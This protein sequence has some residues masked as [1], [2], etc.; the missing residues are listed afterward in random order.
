[1][2]FLPSPRPPPLPDL[3]HI[4]RLLNRHVVGVQRRPVCSDEEAG[5]GVGDG[6]GAGGT[7][8]HEEDYE[9]RGGYCGHLGCCFVGVEKGGC[10]GW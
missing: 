2:N 9:L 1:M 8:D 6:D 4:L 5:D 3:P 10:C 7:E